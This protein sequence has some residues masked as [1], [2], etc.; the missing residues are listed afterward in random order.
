MCVCE[1]AAIRMSPNLGYV[2]VCPCTLVCV[3]LCLK[4]CVGFHAC[5][6]LF[7]VFVGAAACSIKA[8]TASKGGRQQVKYQGRQQ[9]ADNSMPYACVCVAT[10]KSRPLLA[11]GKT[12][13]RSEGGRQAACP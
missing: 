12:L 13:A 11:S 4:E 6:C 7:F 1:K 2:I 9:E 10:G 3:R 5:V 8:G